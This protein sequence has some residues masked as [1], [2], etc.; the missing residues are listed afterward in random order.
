MKALLVG[1]GGI[2]ETWLKAVQAIPAIELVALVDLDEN[3][4]RRRANQFELNVATGVDLRKTI[5]KVKPDVVFDCTVPQAHFSVTL[6]ALAAGCHVFGEK[7]MADSFEQATKMIEA[8]DKAGRVYAVIQNRRY[9]PNLRRLRQFLSTGAVG[10]LTTIDADFYIAPRF[11]GFREHMAHVI[12]KDMA[13]HTFD[14]AR[15]LSQESPQAV[16]CHEWNPTGSWYDQDAAAVA[17]F[18]MTNN[19]TFSYRGS[20]CAEGLRTSWASKWRVVGT[21]GSVSWN[22]ED[23]F[24]AE[25]VQDDAGFLSTYASRRVPETISEAFL[26]GHHRALEA[27]VAALDKGENPETICTDNVKSLAMVLGAVESTTTRQRV[28]IDPE[29]GSVQGFRRF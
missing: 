9:K 1:C 29:A 27:C 12:V 8:A 5:D 23:E 18:E 7:P 20:W 4:A 24:K 26:S 11:G 19:V 13:I 15:F 14:A 28:V 6:T 25:V 17:I 21:K 10:T 2:S 22:G 16:Y 3:E